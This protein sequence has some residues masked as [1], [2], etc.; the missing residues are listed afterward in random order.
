VSWVISNLCR[1]KHPQ[2]SVEVV[3]QLMP[4]LTLLLHHPDKQV[5]TDAC[6]AFA[7]ISDG[8][9]ERIDLVLKLGVLNRLA[10]LSGSKDPSEVAP[11][12]RTLGN[13]VTGDDSQTDAVIETGVLT[14]IM[15]AVLSS[16]KSSLTREGCWMISNVAAGNATQIQSIID[17]GLIPMIIELTEKGDFRTQAEAVWVIFNVCSGGTMDQACYLLQSGAIPGVCRM[18]KAA[19]PRILS[20]VLDTIRLLLE[21][22][23]KI[24]ET[25]AATM[26]V[27]ECGG[28]DE[29]EILQN[30]TNEEVYQKA[31]QLVETYFSEEADDS[32]GLATGNGAVQFEDPTATPTEGFNF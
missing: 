18:L 32:N 1:H 23:T 4:T 26:L 5:M 31:L 16:N 29:I 15:P 7:Y 12:L 3:N 10:E 11:S 6:W 27:E 9:D 21:T 25:E 30:H 24:G 22:A 17:A 28:L 20:L 14:S 2:V 19:D 8:S 13:I